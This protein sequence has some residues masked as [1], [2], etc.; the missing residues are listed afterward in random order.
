[1]LFTY[2][3]FTYPSLKDT[4]PTFLKRFTPRNR[5]RLIPWFCSRAFSK[6]RATNAWMFGNSYSISYTHTPSPARTWILYSLSDWIVAL[7][8]CPISLRSLRLFT[9]NSIIWLFRHNTPIQQPYISVKRFNHLLCDYKLCVQIIAVLL[10]NASSFSHRFQ[11]GNLT[12]ELLDLLVVFPF[13][14]KNWTTCGIPDL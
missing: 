5:I 11:N 9:I 10:L 13:H 7:N 3:E 14:Q 8:S 2:D 1:M 12:P 4:M 6:S